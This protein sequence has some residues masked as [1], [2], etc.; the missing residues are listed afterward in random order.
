MEK[1]GF[2]P[3]EP[4]TAALGR[5]CEES[6]TNLTTKAGSFLKLHKGQQRGKWHHMMPRKTFLKFSLSVASDMEQLEHL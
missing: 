2:N 3:G 5:E 1:P 4:G 6:N